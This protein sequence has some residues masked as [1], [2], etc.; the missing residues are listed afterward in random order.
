MCQI[1]RRVQRHTQEKEICY[2]NNIVK[3]YKLKSSPYIFSL[4]SKKNVFL[5]LTITFNKKVF[6]ERYITLLYKI[7][8][9]VATT[10]IK[11]VV[12]IYRFCEFY[13]TMI[14]LFTIYYI[15][16]IICFLYNFLFFLIKLT[17]PKFSTFH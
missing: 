13:I 4:K 2:R 8:K 10:T 11:T 17:N 5:I 15:I 7:F 1:Y 16:H 3:K 9:N 6:K 14:I 12:Q